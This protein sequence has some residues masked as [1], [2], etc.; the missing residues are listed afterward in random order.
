MP[1]RWHGASVTALEERVI[2]NA[3]YIRVVVRQDDG[4]YAST[5]CKPVLLGSSKL[6]RL[7]LACRAHPT[8]E[9]LSQASVVG[10]RVRVKTERKDAYLNILDVEADS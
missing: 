5:L 4:Q 8:E 10:R 9:G 3:R 7:M 2:N 6:T 1:G